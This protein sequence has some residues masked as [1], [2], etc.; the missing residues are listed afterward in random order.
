[1][2]I[3]NRCLIWLALLGLITTP[4]V[5]A[6]ESVKIGF[7]PSR[8]RGEIVR[9]AKAFC[10]YV[11]SATGMDV[12]AVVSKNYTAGVSD[13]T[14]GDVDIAWLSPISLV[15]AESAG[16]A[17]VLLKA[18][19]REQPFYWGAVVVRKDS[20]ITTI[21][22]LKD[23]RFGWTDPTSTAGHLVTKAALLRAGVDPEGHFESNQ[24]LGAHDRLVEAVFDGT[25][26]AGA[27]FANLPVKGGGGAWHVY[28]EPE[29]A[30]QIKAIFFTEPIPGDAVAGSTTFLDARKEVAE[31][32]IRCLIA[33]GENETGKK[34]LQDL[35]NIDRLANA[36][37]EDYD[38]VRLAVD[39]LRG[40]N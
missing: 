2:T 39:V 14:H 6:A 4:T 9:A 40:G 32:L 21:E 7:Y 28:L 3:R 1:M 16:K 24:F 36:E 5:A 10:Q 13:L 12:N 25:V 30:E 29:Q 18:V 31:P 19:R 23:K 34:L 20:G 27:T 22:A 17:R 35:Y 33:M 38:T 11:S 37:S 8:E 15:S 26:D